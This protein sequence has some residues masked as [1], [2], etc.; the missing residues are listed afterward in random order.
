M[1]KFYINNNG[2]K[3]VYNENY[4]KTI[5][6]L[7][8]AME[9]WL[10]NQPFDRAVYDPTYRINSRLEFAISDYLYDI[11]FKREYKL[12]YRDEDI[13]TLKDGYG[14]MLCE[15]MI[16]VKQDTTEGKVTRTFGDNMWMDSKFKDYDSAFGAI[17]SLLVTLMPQQALLTGLYCKMNRHR[18]N[19]VFTHTFDEKTLTTYTESSREQ[20]I[21]ML[22]KELEELKKF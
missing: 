1:G 4:Y 14:C 8:N 16:E 12:G 21:K 5:P 17:N 19:E 2:D 7:I 15:L 20:T 18:A 11:G 9:M 6:E 10:K 3:Y 22:E 13:Y